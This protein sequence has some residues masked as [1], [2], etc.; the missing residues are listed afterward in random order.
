MVHVGPGIKI[1]SHDGTLLKSLVK[2]KS[3]SLRPFHN[4]FA[5]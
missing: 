2:E 1:L 3:N 4:A 5:L